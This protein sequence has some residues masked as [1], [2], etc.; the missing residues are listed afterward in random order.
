MTQRMP[1]ILDAPQWKLFPGTSRNSLRVDARQH[2]IT[3]ATGPQQEYDSTN[4]N[5]K[6]VRGTL[7]WNFANG[8]LL[9]LQ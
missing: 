8:W 1:I 4:K 2:L 3:I 5:S 7:S 6:N 9:F